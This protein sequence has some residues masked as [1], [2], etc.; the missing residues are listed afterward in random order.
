MVNSPQLDLAWKF[1]EQTATNIFLTGRAASGDFPG[2]VNSEN[3][4]EIPENL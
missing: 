2:S 3:T 1:L 4:K